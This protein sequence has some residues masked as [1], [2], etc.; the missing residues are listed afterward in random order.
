MEASF[1]TVR[2]SLWDTVCNTRLCVYGSSVTGKLANVTQCSKSVYGFREFP[3]TPQLSYPQESEINAD[4]EHFFNERYHGCVRSF[5]KNM[6]AWKNIYI[7][8]FL[9]FKLDHIIP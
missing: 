3:P 5:Y 9:T 7:Y 4:V 8:L 2:L 1:K 6:L